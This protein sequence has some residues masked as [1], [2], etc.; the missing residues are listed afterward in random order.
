MNKKKGKWKEALGEALLE[1]ILS[2]VLF[3]IGALILLPFGIHPDDERLDSDL[4]ILVGGAALLLLGGG[5]FFAIRGW[6]KKRNQATKTNE[7]QEQ[8]ENET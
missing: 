7:T 1:V 5:L 6:K 3:G 4:V 2:V 8:K